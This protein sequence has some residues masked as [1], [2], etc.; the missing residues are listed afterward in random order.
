MKEQ[1]IQNYDIKAQEFNKGKQLSLTDYLNPITSEMKEREIVLS[2]ISYENLVD[3]GN[4][5]KGK[6]VHFSLLN[7]EMVEF[8]NQ[9]F[10]EQ[11]S[12]VR[13]IYKPYFYGMEI[14]VDS[15]ANHYS[16]KGLKNILENQ[17][18]GG[19]CV[20]ELSKDGALSL[21]SKFIKKY[22]S[23][24][25]DYPIETIIKDYKEASNQ[26]ENIKLALAERSENTF[27]GFGNVTSVMSPMKIANNVVINIVD[28]ERVDRYKDL[29]HKVNKTFQTNI[30]R[31]WSKN[32]LNALA[33]PS[34]VHHVEMT[35]FNVGQANFIQ[36][37]TDK[38]DCVVFDA[39]VPNS[40]FDNS[41]GNPDLMVEVNRVNP[42][43]ENISKI[44]T[45]D[46]N[47][48][49]ISHWHDDHIKGYYAMERV[50]MLN[51]KWIMPAYSGWNDTNK[52][53]L[54]N[55]LKNNGIAY[56][57]S[58]QQNSK[59]FSNDSF[60][61]YR[62]NSGSGING[63]PDI[64]KD[65]LILLILNKCIL[66]GDSEYKC[67][68][69]ELKNKSNTVTDLVV[70]HHGG[71]ADLRNKTI[72]PNFDS[73]MDKRAYLSTGYSGDIS[74]FPNSYQRKYLIIDCNFTLQNTRD[75]IGKP[76][77]VNSSHF[78]INFTI[79]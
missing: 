60:E 20:L 31:V 32:K 57:I 39:G 69:I 42:I 48:C 5:E 71:Y 25:N 49:F 22:R 44:C 65:G 36:G 38:N 62:G 17:F 33:L 28:D 77:T 7:L 70:P 68:P 66:P 30:L 43:L 75:L 6:I 10:G 19:W 52:A 74:K 51:A 54:S 61:L 13:E 63:K 1:Y 37:T 16:S 8:D 4:P 56:E 3:Y 78:S 73:G 18:E 67:W 23:N 50:N 15:D 12:F 9:Y 2:K 26:L 29:I 46:P 55:F 21:P 11:D 79:K 41:L 72:L 24:F 35:V 64:N 14:Y 59:I 27:C 53:R 76:L 45:M 47:Y 58:G 40:K 34:G